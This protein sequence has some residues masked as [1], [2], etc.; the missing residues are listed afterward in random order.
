ML[1]KKK[2]KMKIVPEE[3]EGEQRGLADFDDVEMGDG[4]SL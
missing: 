4:E 1:E 3:S 2:K